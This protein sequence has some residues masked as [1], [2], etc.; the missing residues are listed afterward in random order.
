VKEQTCQV[1]SKERL[2]AYAD[3]DVS[4]GEAE[5]IAKHIATC[6]ECHALS[7][8][9]NRSL[10]ITQVIWQTGEAR[11]P[12][13]QSFDEFRAKRRSFRKVIAV[14]ASILLLFGVGLLWQ[15]LT[16]SSEPTAADIE[17]IANRTAVAAQMLAVANL[18]G[19]QPAGQEYAVKR[20]NY[21]IDS[22]PGME[23]SAQAKKR[24]TKLTERRV[25]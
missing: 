21:I 23:E 25:E 9:L 22:F 6:P 13:T 19:S 15:L 5:H 12:E 18:L 16:Q 24:L 17:I 4:P 1:V 8:A 20:Y 2:V 14:A 3:G 10:Q 11:W 7:E